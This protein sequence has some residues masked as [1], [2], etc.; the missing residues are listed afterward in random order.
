MDYASIVE[1]IKKRPRVKLDNRVF[2]KEI[3]QLLLGKL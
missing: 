2:Y 3:D 1:E